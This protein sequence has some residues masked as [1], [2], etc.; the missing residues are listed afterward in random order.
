MERELRDEAVAAALEETEARAAA[1]EARRQ[2][3]ADYAAAL[4][5]AKQLEDEALSAE[6]ASAKLAA[7]LAEEEATAAEVAAMAAKV[8]AGLRAEA[9]AREA[10]DAKLSRALMQA[11]E[12]AVTAAAKAAAARDAADA[13]LAAK[14]QAK[15]AKEFRVQVEKLCEAWRNPKLQT[16]NTPSGL[17]VSCYLPFLRRA[18]VRPV[19]S[20]ASPTSASSAS[21]TADSG[22]GLTVPSKTEPSSSSSSTTS[23]SPATAAAGGGGGSGGSGSAGSSAGSSA[24][25]IVATSAVTSPELTVTVEPDFSAFHKLMAEIPEDLRA[26][27]VD[28]ALDLRIVGKDCSRDDDVRLSYDVATGVLRVVVRDAFI[29][30]EKKAGWMARMRTGLKRMFSF[31]TEK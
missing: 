8:E 29:A 10:E 13:K 20:S 16:E 22:A 14:M 24:S 5:L 4:S 31:K 25:E 3:Q 19:A 17:V 11:E 18:E 21:S 26:P 9:A 1:E 6:A 12:K 23:S 28:L 15:E 2:E 27:I 7:A 30:E